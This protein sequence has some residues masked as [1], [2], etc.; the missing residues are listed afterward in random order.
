MIAV[1]ILVQKSYKSPN[2]IRGIEIE[3]HA[4]ESDCVT[5]TKLCEEVSAITQAIYV[6]DY[7]HTSHI[8]KG[9]FRYEFN[10]EEEKRIINN[11]MCYIELLVSY[12]KVLSEKYRGLI[13]F[14][15]DK[16]SY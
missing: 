15:K 4:Q 1:R 6:I 14:Q 11:C 7:Q 9:Q 12:L 3:G 2:I 13:D 16:I 5:N 8:S 10:L